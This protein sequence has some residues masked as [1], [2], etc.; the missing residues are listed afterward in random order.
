ME[1][2]RNASIPSV[3][4]YDFYS[5][6]VEDMGFQATLDLHTDIDGT[7]YTDDFRQTTFLDNTPIINPTTVNTNAHPASSSRP[8]FV[9]SV[10]LVIGSSLLGLLLALLPAHVL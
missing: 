5:G 9:V 3:A 4:G 7:T 1:F 8:S 6:Y 2:T 10:R